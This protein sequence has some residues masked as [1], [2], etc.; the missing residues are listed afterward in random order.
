M[1]LKIPLFEQIEYDEIAIF[2][3]LLEDGFTY[4]RRP[5]N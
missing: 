1:Y 5:V 2:E 3:T 4:N